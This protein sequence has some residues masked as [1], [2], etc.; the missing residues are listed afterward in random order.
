MTQ[1]ALGTVGAVVGSFFGPIGASI[2][3]TLGSA[4]GSLLDPKKIEGPR[5]TDRRLHD[6][7]YGQ[8]VT[9]IAGTMRAAG[10][11]IWIGNNGEL[12]EHK[13]VEGGKGGPETTTYTYTAS[14]AIG[15]CEGVMHSITRIWADNTL[16]W[17]STGT[18]PGAIPC[19]FYPGSSTQ[20]ADPR[21]VSEEGEEVT[22]AYR[23]TCY[24][25]FED[26][27]LAPY[28]NRIPSLSF[29]IQEGT[30]DSAAMRVVQSNYDD[31]QTFS[32]PKIVDWTLG[33]PFRIVEMGP[34]REFSSPEVTP[35]N[36]RQFNADLS[37]NGAG[38]IHPS[39][40]AYPADIWTDLSGIPYSG[41]GIHISGVE[42]IPLWFRGAGSIVHGSNTDP[43]VASSD[44]HGETVPDRAEGA[45][46]LYTWGIP[47]GFYVQ[48]LAL[49]QYGD[50]LMVFGSTTIGTIDTWYKIG[51]GQVIG[52][53]AIDTV[54]TSFGT[55]QFAAEN[56]GNWIWSF[57]Y[58][59][60][61]MTI[62]SI[63]DDGV[64]RENGTVGTVKLNPA[65]GGTVD[66]HLKVVADGYCGVVATS[67]DVGVFT[68]YPLAA[69]A[70]VR[71]SDVVTR[72]CGMVGFDPA[73]ID[74]TDLE[75]DLVAGYMIASQMSGRDALL[76][77]QSAYFFDGVE[78]A[79]IMKFVKRGHD[80][81]LEIPED[82][83]AA[84]SGDDADIPPLQAIE[85]YH[86]E[87]LP[88]TLNL[89]Y[90]NPETDYQNS[91]QIER[92][93]VTRSSLETTVTLAMSMTHILAKQVAQATIFVAWYERTKFSFSTSRRYAHLDPADVIICRNYRLRIETK[94]DRADDIV[95]FTAVQ[96]FKSLWI[97]GGVPQAG[98]GITPVLPRTKQ[99]TIYALLDVPLLADDDDQFGFRMAM[100]GEIDD[101]WR[102]GTLFKSVDGG[103]SYAAVATDTTDDPIGVA[104][105]V[106]PDFFGG[107]QFDE[108]STVD[109]SIGDGGGDL[110]SVNQAAILNGLNMAVLGNEVFQFKN[111][112]L[113]TGRTYRL[114]GLLRGRKG[115]EFATSGHTVG[116]QFAFLDQTAV[117][118]APL[119]DLNQTRK[120]KGV[121]S[122]GLLS[123]ASPSDFTNLGAALRPYSPVHLG[124]GTDAAGNSTINW[125][126]RTRK[127]GVWLDFVE[128]QL[129]EDTEKYV[130]EIWDAG[131][132]VCARSTV[133]TAATTLAY[134]AAQQVTDFGATQAHVYFTVAQIGSYRLG[135][136][137]R[138]MVPGGG[139]SDGLPLVP[140][141]PYA[142]PPGPPPS[143]TNPVDKVLS[144]H[145]DSFITPAFAIGG[146]IVVSFT[147]SSTPYDA[148]NLLGAQHLDPAYY[149]EAILALDSGG[150][151][152]V[153]TTYGNTFG[154][155]F[156]TGIGQTH[157]LP[158]TTYY[159]LIRTRFANGSPSGPLGASC[160][161]IVNLN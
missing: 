35:I 72:F 137:A 146:L 52:T 143:S 135:S 23:G 113:V 67:G 102:G 95:D 140:V 5:L 28:G 155:Y 42:R 53:G 55:L 79:G 123:D 26:M 41:V 141:P 150:T 57:A 104:D 130:V 96:D 48:G 115:T 60:G 88:A 64:M 59:T 65:A 127:G 16:I 4:L 11:V 18:S 36:V 29:E 131:Y 126:R 142:A 121:T 99:N 3:W 106:L 116:E 66:A 51:V 134:T 70:A 10:N 132:A 68:R 108:L 19:T 160:R 90:V 44:L 37:D 24:V 50:M 62:W 71:L 128:V 13:H 94:T 45:D 103:S 100:A 54:L 46:V 158:S 81:A 109:V 133:V 9:I 80:S 31:V 110:S 84:H 91:T 47:S 39:E 101:T 151:S 159:C 124:G 7:S 92:R 85:R 14:F 2:G 32:N 8:M 111:A 30:I 15:L 75:K 21:M 122:G 86:E 69:S 145:S 61:Y 120:Y 63:G 77:L 1:L 147:T 6:S 154:F 98:S 49:N 107:N 22:P 33:S 136:R 74:V 97:Q 89:V 157:L 83:L 40:D 82:E 20:L 149:R 156:G 87:E 93:Q 73:E 117:V 125:T 118:P 112:D 43:P 105:T 114:S 148:V 17:D 152:V 34:V 27:D 161:M 139:G 12:V 119:A 38:V 153:A 138:G 129:G 56:D 76:A 58:N 25:V 78:T 144:F